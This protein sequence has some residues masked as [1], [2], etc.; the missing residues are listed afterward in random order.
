[1][2]RWFVRAVL[3]I[4]LGVF[5][6]IVVEYLNGSRRG[7]RTDLDPLLNQPIDALTVRNVPLQVAVHDLIESAAAGTAIRVCRSLADRPV[8]LAVAHPQPLHAVLESLAAQVGVTPALANTR[9]PGDR[10]LP[11]IP[12]PDG[13]GDYL[14]IGSRARFGR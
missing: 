6:F 2:S 11:T 1:M 10:V 5:A 12:C 14:V 8:S 4:I 7:D 13:S 9:Q 3:P